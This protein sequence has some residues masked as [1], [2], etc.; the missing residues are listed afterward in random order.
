MKGLEVTYDIFKAILSDVEW[1]FLLVF[2]DHDNVF[3]D[4]AKYSKHGSYLPIKSEFQSYMIGFKFMKDLYACPYRSQDDLVCIYPPKKPSYR[5]E[6][7]KYKLPVMK[8]IEIGHG[9]A[10]CD[11]VEHETIDVYK[12]V[13]KE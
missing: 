11:R 8:D 3:I 6:F 12:K 7:V 2:D 13:L 9:D 1:Q 5:V 10:A 4:L